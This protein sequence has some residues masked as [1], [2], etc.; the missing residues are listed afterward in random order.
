[1][2]PISILKLY[3]SKIPPEV[4][5]NTIKEWLELSEVAGVNRALAFAKEYDAD[6][7]F[8]KISGSAPDGIR[9]F[10]ELRGSLFF[11]EGHMDTNSDYS[12]LGSLELYKSVGN[13]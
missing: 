2:G 9:P 1:L 3:D 5:R 4:Y 12:L 11:F 7:V 10:G 8:L 6:N 13:K